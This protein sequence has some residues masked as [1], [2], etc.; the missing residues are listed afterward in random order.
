MGSLCPLQV[1]FSFD[2][3]SLKNRRPGLGLDADLSTKSSDLKKLG[4]QN[5]TS[6]PRRLHKRIP[7]LM[8]I[9]K[10]HRRPEALWE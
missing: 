8:M 6:D 9:S 1:D 4:R 10:R 3:V 2:S 5:R 7:S